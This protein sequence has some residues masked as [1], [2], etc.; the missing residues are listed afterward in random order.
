M[1]SRS[2]K[3]KSKLDGILRSSNK[4]NEIRAKYFR[5][6]DENEI[7]RS[8]RLVEQH[9]FFKEIINLNRKD[10][11]SKFYFLTV[12]RTDLGR[13]INWALGVLRCNATKINYFINT[14]KN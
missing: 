4:Q 5:D 7:G 11:Y 13:S 6:L 3:K 12:P 9:R 8:V 14:V 2:R 1:S 10:D